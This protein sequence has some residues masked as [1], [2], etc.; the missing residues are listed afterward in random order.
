MV[1]RLILIIIIINKVAYFSNGANSEG[2]HFPNKDS[3]IIGESRRI[4]GTEI[5]GTLAL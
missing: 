2:V 5:Y 1:K 3:G 4:L